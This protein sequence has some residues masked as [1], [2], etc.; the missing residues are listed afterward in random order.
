MHAFISYLPFKLIY[1][2]LQLDDG[3]YLGHKPSPNEPYKWITYSE[4]N[5]IGHELGS[6]FVKFGLEP[7]KESFIGIY[8]RNRPEW[9][10]TEVASNAFSFVNVPL[11]ETLGVEAISFILVQSQMRFVVCDDSEKA[12]QLMNSKSNLEYIIVIDKLNEEAK[13]KA[14]ELDIKIMTF[15][16]CREVG[17]NNLQP[18]AFVS[19]LFW[20]KNKF[21][22]KIL[23]RIFKYFC[24]ATETR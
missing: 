4:A 6:A 7:A 24:I 22:Q 2:F 8:A 5:T 23:N 1:S 19:T 16:A 14:A 18:K 20:C 13:A 3:P 15:D 21:F 11:Y 17:R 10:L 12:L 9:V